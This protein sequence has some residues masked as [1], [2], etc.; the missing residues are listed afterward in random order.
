M[1][2]KFVEMTRSEACDFIFKAVNKWIDK[3]EWHTTSMVFDL[4]IKWNDANP[5]ESEI[6]GCEYYDESIEKNCDIGLMVEDYLFLF[7]DY[8]EAY[9]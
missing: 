3:Y 8:R 4:I 2:K 7:P 9:N 5:D 6:F 1:Q